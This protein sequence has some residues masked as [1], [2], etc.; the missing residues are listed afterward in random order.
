MMKQV[1]QITAIASI[2]ILIASC[3]GQKKNETAA[4]TDK[5][6]A[7][8]KLKK[9]RSDAD[10]E[11]RKLQDE[12]MKIDSNAM[13]EARVK[14]VIVAPVGTQD[15]KHY[16]DLRGK[17]E[18][19]NNSYISPR[20]MGGQVRAVYVKEGQVV[21]KGQLLLKLDDAI[22]RQSVVAAR[23]QQEG[24]RTQLGLAR[25][26][27]DRKKNLWEKGIGT[28]VE[29]LSAKTNV[30]GL[31]AQLKAM[32]EQANVAVEQLNTS[33]VYSDVNGV[34]DVVN[35][36][37]GE[38]FQ[39]MTAQGTPQIKIVNKSSLKAVANIP[40]NYISRVQKGTPVLVSLADVN[41]TI[42]TSISLISQSID[43]TQRGF[44]AEAK[45][46][47]D[48]SLKPDQSVVMKIMDYSANAA[49]VIPVNTIQ[50]DEKNK[51]V[52][53]L[54]KAG[55]GRSVARKKIVSIG[56]IYGEMVEVK[57]GLS[58]GEQLITEGYQNLY[59]GQLVSTEVK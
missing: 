18:A 22:A 49:V 27:Y 26:I 12:L 20:G 54:E 1:K 25:S 21:R 37:V 57:S 5:R 2:V 11:I 51:Y 40:E 50:S 36:R 33:S 58:A 52:Y 14:L 55:N 24:V 48:A 6:A 29:L 28:E 41:K 46:P 34:A 17:I 15:F 9:E 23:Q 56:E 39:G 53:V 47:A 38:F 4:I 45:I 30:E 32:N 42:N 19:E 8:E 13:N 16:I 43:P 3:G 31:E 44:L 59:E 10:A 7:I 35:I